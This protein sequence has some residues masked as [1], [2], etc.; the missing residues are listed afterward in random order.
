[1][2]PNRRRESSRSTPAPLKGSSSHLRVSADDRPDCQRG[3]RGVSPTQEIGRPPRR[4]PLPISHR[5]ETQQATLAGR[6]SSRASVVIIP[7]NTY[8]AIRDS[9]H[10][11]MNFSTRLGRNKRPLWVALGLGLGGGR[12]RFLRR[13]SR[14]CSSATRAILPRIR[15]E[16]TVS[17]D[18]FP[19]LP[20]PG[21]VRSRFDCSDTLVKSSA[22]PREHPP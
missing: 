15:R 5:P 11:E 6:P 7:Q 19:S 2:R 10:H 12:L 22:L 3:R 8:V 4:D 9:V 14:R 18:F 20:R 21:W 16:S 17:G 1:M 13:V